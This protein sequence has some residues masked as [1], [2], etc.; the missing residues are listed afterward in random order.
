MNW[1]KRR[2]KVVIVE[3]IIIVFV[4]ILFVV[5][6]V[7]DYLVSRGI[8]FHIVTDFNDISLVLLQIQ[9]TITTITLSIIALLSGAINTSYYGVPVSMFYLE[10]K[11]FLLK[12][13]TVI[14]IEF[15][16][17]V[18]NIWAHIYSKYNTVIALFMGS[19]I[20][21][22]ASI[23]EVYGIFRG[24]RVT[25]SE[26]KDYVEFLFENDA[27]YSVV[28]T[29]FI[30]DW[31]EIV[32][33]QSSEEFENYMS[34][35][36]K[37][38]IRIISKEKDTDTLNSLTE[39]I[40]YY[41]LSHNT[42]LCQARGIK[43][44]TNYYER[45]WRWIFHNQD[46]AKSI[47]GRISLLD[48]L[49]HDYYKAMSNIDAEELEDFIEWDSFSDYVIRVALCIGFD[50]SRKSDEISSIY[51][52]ADVLGYYLKE[53]Y[54]KNN[55]V[56]KKYWESLIA[57]KYG[58]TTSTIPEELGPIYRQSMAIR[59][60]NVCRG[61]L[62]NSLTEFVKNGFFLNGIRNIYTIDNEQ[63]VLRLMLVHCFMYYLAFDETEEC[64]DIESQ[65][66]IQDIL[67]DKGVIKSITNFYFVLSD[68]RL[69]LT[70][71]LGK[72]LL[73]TLDRYELFP[74]HSSAKTCIIDNSIKKY[75]LFSVL[76][77]AFY[78]F[79]NSRIE[80][81]LNVDTYSQY[82]SDFKREDLKKQLMELHT[83]FEVDYE[84]NDNR[85]IE[86]VLM[87][88]DISMKA[89][90]KQQVIEKAAI[91]QRNYE[92]NDIQKIVED[93]IKKALGE[94]FEKAFSNYSIPNDNIKNYENVRIFKCLHY[95]SYLEDGLN[96]LFINDPLI[97]LWNWMYQ[98]LDKEF[99]IDEMK[100]EKG[101]TD[102]EFRKKLD[103]QKFTKFLGAGSVFA[104]TDYEHR[105]K[106]EDY[107]AKK[108]CNFIPGTNTGIATTSDGL[109]IKVNSINVDIYSPTTSE[110]DVERNIE[111]D[112]YEYKIYDSITLDFTEKEFREFIHDE[113][114]IID[115]RVNVS[116]GAKLDDENNCMLIVRG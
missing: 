13:K 93:K 55:I 102:S 61:Y 56:D 57:D 58:Y 23:L 69:D 44:L 39:N 48:R 67:L 27:N 92:T 43:F 94:R 114:K 12:Q 16:C 11:P 32:S 64:I 76:F 112:S 115:I 108:I 82:L 84:K 85:F 89:K 96:R 37:L 53:Q 50:S 24:R 113:R 30:D 75:Y 33:L 22:V 59:D 110:I 79:S 38:L 51:S 36:H 111:N 8:V 3:S 9:A 78:S 34:F 103:G 26:I 105:K 2:K 31:K 72:E 66:E 19:M 99:K 101:L 45:I 40:A 10:K 73:R 81:M 42:K 6:I 49:T 20:I 18:I 98:V 74:I 35:F 65:K 1:K 88:F 25:L 91:S 52:L 21:I 14:I 86:D 17:M 68:S 87:N 47:N 100:R 80:S 46:S 70:D 107:L 71:N 54:A 29:C 95:T 28:G 109:F 41:L 62:M 116:I 4:S 83:I 7:C 104:C 5:G 90:Y 77:L 15:M 60:F 63:I 106:H 97:N